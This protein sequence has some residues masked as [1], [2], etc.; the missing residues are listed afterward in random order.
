[1]KTLLVLLAVLFMSGCGA[2]LTDVSADINQAFQDINIVIIVD[3]EQAIAMAL[4]ATDQGPPAPATRLACYQAVLA[5]AQAKGTETALL[6]KGVLSAA[7]LYFEGSNAVG[8]GITGIIPVAIHDACAPLVL[9]VLQRGAR[10]AIG[11]FGVP[12]LGR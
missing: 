6:P 9:T 2:L 1:M 5:H 11:A 3:A 10:R 12:M 8:A 4:K 7:E